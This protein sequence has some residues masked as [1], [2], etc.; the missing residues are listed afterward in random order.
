MTLRSAKKKNITIGEQWRVLKH[1]FVNLEPDNNYPKNEVFHH[2]DEDILC[3]RYQDYMID[4]GFYGDYLTNRSGVFK[5]I[6]SKGDFYKGEEFEIF[7]SRSTDEIKAKLDFYL[8]HIPLGILDNVTG[9]VR[10]ANY[11]YENFHVYSALNNISYRITQKQIDAKF[12]PK[13]NV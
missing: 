3:V 1:E 7:I 6:V 10:D 2:F 5:L 4:L 9:L 8:K 13:K 12:A 11:S